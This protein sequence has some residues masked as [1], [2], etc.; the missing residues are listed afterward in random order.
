MCVCVCVCLRASACVC[1]HV[2]VCTYIKSESV[3]IQVTCVCI[4]KGECWLYVDLVR[5]DSVNTNSLCH[6]NHDTLLTGL[7]CEDCGNQNKVE[8]NL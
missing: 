5:A 3:L 7:F 6:K 8:Y 1:M 4:V 2:G